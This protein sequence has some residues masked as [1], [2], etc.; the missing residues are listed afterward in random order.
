[1][2]KGGK[3]ITKNILLLTDDQNAISEAVSQYP[4]YND[5]FQSTK[6]PG[7][8]RW[9]WENQIPSDDRKHEVLTIL[10]TLQLVR[11]CKLLIHGESNFAEYVQKDMQYYHSSQSLN[12]DD[13]NVMVFNVN[14]TKSVKL[15]KSEWKV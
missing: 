5:I 10:S 13:H 14:N 2:K 4:D 1:M 12:I 15:S 6:T 3:N 11:R 7:S 8:R 9:I